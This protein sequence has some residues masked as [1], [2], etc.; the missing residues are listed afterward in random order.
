MSI[1]RR[2]ARD[3]PRPHRYARL[4]TEIN[5][6]RIRVGDYRVLYATSDATKTITVLREGSS[7]A[8]VA[9]GISRL[10]ATSEMEYNIHNMEYSGEFRG[11]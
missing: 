10:D 6:Y 3:S 4:R 11:S 5:T 9:A 8:Q 2:P 1:C 7:S